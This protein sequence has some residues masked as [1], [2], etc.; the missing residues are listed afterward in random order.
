MYDGPLHNPVHSQWTYN[1]APT[2]IFSCAI[3]HFLRNPCNSEST[4]G[5]FLVDFISMFHHDLA[6]LPHS[7]RLQSL[8]GPAECIGPC[9]CSRTSLKTSSTSR[10]SQ[11]SSPLWAWLAPL[12][13][14]VLERKE[15]ISIS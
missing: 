6:D 1:H 12:S 7:H 14:P 15:E 2:N 10:P 4:M 11:R 9:S 8:F 5:W 3:T 13:H